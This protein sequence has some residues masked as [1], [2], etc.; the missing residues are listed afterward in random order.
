MERKAGRLP[1]RLKFTRRLSIFYRGSA[2]PDRRACEIG[3]GK[4]GAGETRFAIS[5]VA[6][7]LM[8]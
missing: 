5:F 4:S 1:R 3:F 2:R 8:I 6:A 7:N